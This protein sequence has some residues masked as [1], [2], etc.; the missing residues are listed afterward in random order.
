MTRVH[1]GPTER[2]SMPEAAPRRG[3]ASRFW[4]G[5]TQT[6]VHHAARPKPNLLATLREWHKRLGL[7][8]FFFMGWL[9]FS[10]FLINQSAGWGYDTVRID[11][12]WVMALYGLHPEPPRTGFNAGDHWLAVTSD[13]TL[14]DAQPLNERIEEPIGFVAGGGLDR[15]LLF[16]ATSS[17]VIMLTP[18]G[19]LYDELRSPILPVSN[20]RRIGQTEDGAIAVQDLDAYQSGDSGDSWQPIDP[21]KVTW[22]TTEA[23]PDPERELLMPYSRPSV[24]LEHVLVDAH[25][26]RLFG[27]F[28]AWVINFVGF[29]AIG[30][31]ISGIWM[32]WR[33]RS[34]RRKVS[35]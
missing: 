33:I 21:L 27:N 4:R 2:P 25:S 3:V 28:G 20:V 31:S 30:L 13:Y 35:R 22:S 26:G 34:N 1:T 17:S 16:V 6:R 24:S 32:W 8:A 29:A 18:D 15:P 10:G 14:L 23:I 11:W 19:G 9:G 5:G 7:F 12:G